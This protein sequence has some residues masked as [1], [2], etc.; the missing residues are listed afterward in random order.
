MRYVYGY[1]IRIKDFEEDFRTIGKHHRYCIISH[2]PLSDEEVI[3]K[4]IRQIT[5]ASCCKH[6]KS[7]EERLQDTRE[8]FEFRNVK[9]LRTY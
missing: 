3:E 9:L 7:L 8:M 5:T 6:S 1:E 4:R 2:T